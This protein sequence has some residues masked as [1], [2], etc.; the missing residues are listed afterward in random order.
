MVEKTFR[1]V[2]SAKLITISA[3]SYKPDYK[4]LSKEEE[5]E[6]CKVSENVEKEKI[7]APTLDLP[8]LMKEM[9]KREYESKGRSLSELPRIPVVL[10]GSYNSNYRCAKEGETPNVQL[11]YGI[12]KTIAPR[13][14]ETK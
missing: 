3:A 11:T 10:K 6:Y 4:L 5:A 14:Y 1:G 7:I 12:G 2:K 13:L 8:P 9:L